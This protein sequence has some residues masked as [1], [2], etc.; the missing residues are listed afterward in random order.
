M[1]RSRSIKV[2]DF[3]LAATGEGAISC[4]AFIESFGLKTL[5]PAFMGKSASSKKQ[6]EKERELNQSAEDI[7][8]L[9]GILSSLFA[10]LP[11]DSPERIRLLAKFVSDDYEKIDKLLEIRDQSVARL[12]RWQAELQMDLDD[13][14]K[15]LEKLENGL[16][17]LQAAD[18]ILAW[19]CMEDDG[20][21]PCPFSSIDLKH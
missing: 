20:V 3:A 9:L 11:S 13:D 2:L 5:F 10:A 18:Y 14:E 19:V 15:L 4:T 21:S 8:H 7:E 16:A 1:A 12:E 17:T 6:K